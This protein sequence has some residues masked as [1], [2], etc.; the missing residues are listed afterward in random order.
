MGLTL[1]LL[2]STSGPAAQRERKVVINI[3]LDYQP[4]ITTPL[5]H[6]SN[7]IQVAF[8]EYLYGSCCLVCQFGKLVVSNLLLIE[9]NNALNVFK[10]FKRFNLFKSA[11][12]ILFV[13]QILYR[14]LA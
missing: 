2:R 13:L 9:C 5:K 11:V 1:S 3:N 4:L 7:F 6:K 10:H 12:S 8:G 14:V